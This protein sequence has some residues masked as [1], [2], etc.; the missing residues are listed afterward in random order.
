MISKVNEIEEVH[1]EDTG[2]RAQ[3]IGRLLIGLK[4][5]VF[6]PLA[7]IIFLTAQP[8]KISA[9]IGILFIVVGAFMKISAISSRRKSVE[10]LCYTGF[11][12]QLRHP[13]YFGTML[14]L[15]GLALYVSSFVYFL[16]T[17][18]F[19]AFYFHYI[20]V[21]EESRLIEEYGQ[22][23]EDYKQAVGTKVLPRKMPQS[24]EIPADIA[25]AV[26][27]DRYFLL[28]LIIIVV[29]LMLVY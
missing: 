3:E 25:A 17:L 24:I 22:S 29:I 9:T 13:E 26:Q 19:I 11:Y 6:V 21:H 28:G 4:D 15:V 20:I 27:E 1:M 8:S 23:Y 2:D 16:I 18:V 10:G 5:M 14:I 7:L 12:S